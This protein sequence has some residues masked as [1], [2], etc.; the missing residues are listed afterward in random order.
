MRM[1]LYYIN[2]CYEQKEYGRVLPIIEMAS[3]YFEVFN[4]D[5]NVAKEFLLTY[6]DFLDISSGYTQDHLDSID[7]ISSKIINML[8][9]SGGD[10]WN[11][12]LL[13]CK[14]RYNNI[15]KE[16]NTGWNLY[17]IE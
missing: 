6:S 4:T 16:Y 7:I 1:Y 15:A 11:D 8:E 2:K 14:R 3:D 17:L 12:D 5:P 10:L 9:K 13:L